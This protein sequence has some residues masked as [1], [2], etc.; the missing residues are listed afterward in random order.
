MA[1]QDKPLGDDE[2][3]ARDDDSKTQLEDEKATFNPLSVKWPEP[4]AGMRPTR[5]VSR[6]IGE[7]GKLSDSAKKDGQSA[8]GSHRAMSA[9]ASQNGVADSSSSKSSPEMADGDTHVAQIPPVPARDA[10]TQSSTMA[11]AQPAPV[12]SHE[13]SPAS[14]LAP[15]PEAKSGS[16]TPPSHLE[17]K[18]GA[19]MKSDGKQGDNA[20]E[21]PT[22]PGTVA[23]GSGAEGS[24]KLKEKAKLAAQ[25][26]AS[27]TSTEPAKDAAPVENAIPV[28]GAESAKNGEFGQGTGAATSPE[29]AKH[30]GASGPV[31]PVAP[32]S[33]GAATQANELGQSTARPGSK[34]PQRSGPPLESKASPPGALPVRGATPITPPQSAPSTNQSAVTAGPVVVP[35]R[36]ADSSASVP[37]SPMVVPP[38]DAKKLSEPAPTRPF[39]PEAKTPGGVGT[40]KQDKPGTTKPNEPGTPPDSS[41]MA[42][43]G[44]KPSD[45]TET[46]LGKG[47]GS[48]FTPAALAGLP[49][50]VTAGSPATSQVPA[51]TD[52]PP[53]R[54][55]V[56]LRGSSGSA[57]TVETEKDEAAPESQH[58]QPA[59]LGDVS[60][61]ASTA[62]AYRAPAPAAT[63]QRQARKGR[64]RVLI[65]LIVLVVLAA[66]YAGLCWF[67]SDRV[68]PGAEVAGVDIGGMS[69]SEAVS[70]LKDELAEKSSGSIALTIDDSSATIDPKEAGLT[71]DASSTVKSVTGFTLNPLTMFDRLFG[72]GQIQPVSTEDDKAL[73]SALSA[74]SET[75][76]IEP[77]EGNVTFV[78]G[79]PEA[80]TPKAG[81]ALNVQKSAELIKRQWLTGKRPLELP[82]Q[83]VNPTIEQDAVD[84]AMESAAVV[85][86]APVTVVVDKQKVV[87]PSAVVTKS[88]SYTPSDGALAL[89]FDGEAMAKDVRA[90]SDLIGTA[91]VEATVR[92]VNNKPVIVPSK[93]GTTIDPVS[94]S[95]QMTEA[96]LSTDNR[97]A[98]VTLTT[99]E[100][101]QSTDAVKKLGIKEVIVDFSTPLT[102]NNPTRTQNIRVAASK[103]NGTIV[104]PGETISTWETIGA[105]TAANGY[106]LA[107]VVSNGQHINAMGGGLSQV[108][109]TMFNAGFFAGFED[110][111]HRP[112]TYWFSRYPAGREA[113]LYYPTLDVK[114]KND[115]PYGALLQMWIEGNRVHIRVWSTPY[116]DVTVKDGPHTN[117]RP[118]GLVTSTSADCQ[119]S[120]G[121]NAGFDVKVHRTVKLNGKTVKSNTLSWSYDADHARRCVA[122]GGSG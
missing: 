48:R 50:A 107:G 119:A 57:E 18:S 93:A 106:G 83:I 70:H 115:S 13:Q 47:T 109:T 111:A 85:A 10:D 55:P 2:S 67:F 16:T 65:I 17:Q 101:S 9:A 31:S 58:A 102:G 19:A 80:V 76:A 22:Q 32:A 113:T 94:L 66:L 72:S 110:K 46:Q 104:K 100:A 35:G 88:A 112:H 122:P 11:A 21:K 4:P 51:P 24:A 5:A 42:K 77:V 81:S 30:T 73:N 91:P 74:I 68:A 20:G 44:E 28:K 84:D 62:T 8:P 23:A 118:V 49:E 64:K 99:L 1:D 14:Q 61:V 59:G 25:E 15:K 39:E 27:T 75:I 43:P 120:S 41:S 37:A 63:Q 3:K 38:M 97:V 90:R 92:I 121:G 86:S 26:A 60:P 45:K 82:T 12:A 89:T 29:S 96:A 114:W 71:F 40:T 53:S 117:T 79:Q 52:T 103:I 78:N 6:K 7:I 95:T 69:S 36:K 54:E 33:P 34:L 108:G 98:N 116:Y 105:P 56:A 87:L